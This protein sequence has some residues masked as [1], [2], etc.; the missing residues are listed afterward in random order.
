M[1]Q[2]IVDYTLDK[3]APTNPDG[4]LP[5]T[6][7]GCVVAAGPGGTVLGNYP[8]ALNFQGGGK[9]TTT[10]P[11]GSL[12]RQKFCLRVIF[13]ADTPVTARQDLLES[14]AL[15]FSFYLAPGTGG[16]AFN[17]VASVRTVSYGVGQASSAFM[18]NLQVGV[19]YAADLV[20][21]TDTL[22]IFVNNVIYSVHAFPDGTLANGTGDQLFAGVALN[23]S[24]YAFG[25]SMALIELHADIPLELE[26]Q[27]DERRG[28]PQWHLTYKQEAIKSYL[29]F[30]EPSGEFYYD[31]TSTAWIQPF[32]A[33]LIMYQDANGLA[34][35]M[36]G[37][38]LQ[39]YQALPNRAELGYLV[40]DEIN[41]AQGG[42]RK[43]LFSGGGIYWSA[44]TGAI[45]VTG[46]MWVDYEA[47]GESR[48]IG[49]P[50][51]AVVL[52]GGGRQQVFQRG[53]MFWRSG[54]SKAFM[55]IG[56]ILAK[57]LA[58]GG[59]ATWGFPVS[60]ENDVMA[61]TTVIG[62]VSEFQYC[63]IYWSGAS[64]AAIIYGE[65][66]NKYRNIG[67]PG[68]R[69]GFPTSD[70]SDV[71][72]AAAPARINSFQ[73]GSIVWFGSEAETYVC[74]AFDIVLGTVDTKESEGWLRGENDIY[75]YAVIDDNGAVLHNERIPSSG[76]HGGHNVYPVDK[77]FDLGPAGII[78]NNIYR[79]IGFTLDV[80]DADWPD[81]DDHLGL[82]NSTLN[83]ANAWGLR[84]NPLGLLNSGSFDNINNISWAVAP[85][86]DVNAWPPAKKWWGVQ[87]Q[88]TDPI[89]YHQYATAFRDVD[90]EPEW[91]DIPDWLK[92]LFY[93][94][95]V[96]GVAKNGNC[97]GMSLEAI[98]SKKDRALLTE[99]VDRFNTWDPTVA[100]EFNIKHQY[101]VGASA[102][103]WFVGEFLTGQTHD[104][105]SVFKATRNAFNAGCDP[106]VCI[107]QHYDFSGAPHCILP[108]G[109]NDSVTP[110]ELQVRDPN[111]PTTS[112]GDPPRILYVDPTA[113][114]FHYD[115]GSVYDGGEWSGGRFHYMPFD[116]VN[117]RPRTPVYEAI[118]LLLTGVVVILGGD[119]QTNTLTDENGVDL[120]AFGADSIARQQA[121]RPLTNKFVSVKGFNMSPTKKK[122]DPA[123][124]LEEKPTDAQTGAQPAAVE[125]EREC[126][127][128]RV[129]P[130][131]SDPPFDGPFRPR[132]RGVLTSEIHMRTNPR[133]YSRVAPPN[134]RGGDDWTRLTLKEYL[135]QVAPAPVRETFRRYPE[136]V[137]QNQ[138]RQMLYL[139]DSDVLSKVLATSR[140]RLQELVDQFPAISP[141]FIHE[142]RTV[143]GG[144]F[145]YAL[146]Q[147][148]SQML[149]TAEAGNGEQ[150]TVKVKN[151]GTYN[152][153]ITLSGYREKHFN[154]QV[155]NK[156]GV[157]S[158]YLRMEL[159]NIPMAAGGNLELNIK[160]G[161]GG[162]ELF[163]AGQAINA[164]VNFEYASRGDTLQSRFMLQEQEGLRV[165]PSTFI[166]SNQLKV[167]R[168]DRIF[169]DSL[170]SILLPP[171][172]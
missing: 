47:M 79:N 53:Q 123:Q 164:T 60:D 119:S 109:W 31:F 21:D 19:W 6:V 33:G 63:T 48:A 66:R 11:L 55:V 157:G 81:D 151:L 25:G 135:C 147:G 58:T 77:R 15:P 146:K 167:N 76:D 39:A 110:W 150:N 57:F 131:P 74:E 114:T 138:G 96:K 139:L 65:I 129:G 172:P 35:E 54:S 5:A 161:I 155:H 22:A 102:I 91:W 24:S 37:A 106:V 40:S 154:L 111:F 95:A 85:H 93:E 17:L 61:G 133:R 97:F 13:R 32:P 29:A 117:E 134:K 126:A 12:N 121:G 2:K 70:E 100:N 108:V 50:V 69:L 3:L 62:R 44:G 8:Q 132:P 159:D 14:N 88:S 145:E 52:I 59:T 162:L 36:H 45:A 127:P 112:D 124:P 49:L 142:T 75:M 120:D 7:S 113:N 107:A 18:L 168:I 149:V 83:A 9:L 130:K 68:G 98:Y 122:A 140:D 80:W 4:S 125:Y 156:L 51:A 141:N 152:N 92:K 26:S 94:V 71:P 104:P 170:S 105:V 118:M 16:S 84:G 72:G 137:E 28:H 20:Y 166:T 42:S 144:V 67:G 87:N 158:D 86:G 169:G 78:P 73:N 143:R 41:A 153:I 27:L 56:A 165:V 38:I 64:G 34:F 99:P 163:S 171:M 116:L 89:T 46:Q 103:W 82:L 115:G 160:P 43:S 90:S 101:Q 30:G 10:L 1:S 148:L 23:G 128:E 136:F